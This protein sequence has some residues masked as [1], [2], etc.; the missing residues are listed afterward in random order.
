MLCY[1]G[2]IE[3]Q[4]YT[5]GGS[6]VIRLLAPKT[7]NLKVPPSSSV[8]HPCTIECTVYVKLN[9][10]VSRVTTPIMADVEHFQLHIDALPNTYVTGISTGTNTKPVSVHPY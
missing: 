6:R 1:N 4:Y 7:L 8:L 9:H 5:V 2:P 3:S 10:L